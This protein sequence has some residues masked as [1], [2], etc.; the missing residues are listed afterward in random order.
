MQVDSN[1]VIAAATVGS[2]VIP[3]VGAWINGVRASS[4]KV[5]ERLDELVAGFG[6]YKTYVA[7]HYASREH[8]R[9]ALSPIHEDLKEIRRALGDK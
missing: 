7:E 1:Y 3:I 6:D 2:V 9:E 8:L 5:H 4:K